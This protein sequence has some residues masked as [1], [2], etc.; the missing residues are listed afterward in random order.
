LPEVP[1][2]SSNRYRYY[3]F[4]IEAIREGNVIQLSEF[5][6]I[7]SNGNEIKPLTLYAYTGTS[8]GNESQENLFDDDTSTKYCGSFTAGTTLY[9][10]IDAGKKVEL[11]GYRMTTGN[12]TSSYPGRNP[13]SWSLLASNTQ[14]EQPDDTAWVLLDHRENDNTLS[15]INYT[16]FDFTFTYPEPVT[17]GD[18]NGDGEVDLSDAIMVTYYS[19]HQ[20]PSNFNADAADMNGDGTVDLSDAI[21]IIYM[22]L[23]VK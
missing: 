6:L 23:G 9:I 22:S 21:I 14:S 3:Q 8:F 17:S 7:D 1:K 12:D 18:V 15:A 13:V 10:Y 5:D 20:A 16:P 11:S 4:A 19:L 2:L